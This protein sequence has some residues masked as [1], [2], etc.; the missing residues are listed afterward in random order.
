MEG[1]AFVR[2]SGWPVSV[3]VPPRLSMDGSKMFVFG[4][5]SCR[6]T[7]HPWLSTPRP[8]DREEFENI[9]PDCQTMSVS[10]TVSTCSD[11][12]RIPAAGLRAVHAGHAGAGGL[13]NF[14]GHDS[15]VV[16]S[17]VEHYA[18]P[19]HHVVMRAQPPPVSRGVGPGCW[20]SGGAG[21]VAAAVAGAA[22]GGN[23]CGCRWHAVRRADAGPGRRPQHGARRGPPRRGPAHR[24]TRHA[25]QPHAG[26]PHRR[27]VAVHAR[28]R[29]GGKVPIGVER[30]SHP[31]L[32]FAPPSR[33]WTFARLTSSRSI[34]P[35]FHGRAL[36]RITP[37]TPF[38]NGDVVG[39][40]RSRGDRVTIAGKR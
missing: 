4:P 17:K 19:L 38:Q 16:P 28:C 25:R 22:A 1:A 30:T 13:P 15:V 21:L 24:V 32:P 12:Q 9:G 33:C 37:G 5:L 27:T 8:E 20:A 10:T 14:G 18:Q 36:A 26:P 23:G 29:R 35:R 39:A 3:P 34:A 40:A 2:M 7:A 6:R 11:L 31:S